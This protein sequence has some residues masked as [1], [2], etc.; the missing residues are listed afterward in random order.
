MDGTP[1]E[2]LIPVLYRIHHFVYDCYP[3]DANV[4]ELSDNTIEIM[5]KA[6]RQLR[7]AEI[8]AHRVDY[9]M[10][11]DDSEDTLQQRLQED[12]EVFEKEFQSKDWAFLDDY[13]D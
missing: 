13:D 9:M 4:L 11:G 1:S 5:K 2:E 3:Y 10:S 7:I 12:L 8:Y 6:Y